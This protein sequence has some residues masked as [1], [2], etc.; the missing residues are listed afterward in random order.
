MKWS[1]RKSETGRYTEACDGPGGIG[2]GN[3][4]KGDVRSSGGGATD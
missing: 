2:R 3:S 1:L 4:G